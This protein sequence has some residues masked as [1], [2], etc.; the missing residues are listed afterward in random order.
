[1]EGSAAQPAPMPTPAPAPKGRTMMYVVVAVVTVIIIVAAVAAILLVNN[2]GGGGGAGNGPSAQWDPQTGNRLDYSVSV[3]EG[4]FSLSGSMHMLVK[5]VSGN[6][7]VVNI[8]VTIG[9]YTNYTEVTTTKANATFAYLNA[10]APSGTPVT[11]ENVSLPT[12]WGV[13]TCQHVSAS[14]SGTTF[15]VY[16][17]ENILMKMSM[18]TS[19]TYGTVSIT[20]TLTGTNFT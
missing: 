10:E 2:N 1:M 13:K 11:Y 15:D 4:D 16:S 17:Y 14:T 7:V 12:I 20:F 9:G 5:S 8:T 6:S 19:S 18:S 3:L